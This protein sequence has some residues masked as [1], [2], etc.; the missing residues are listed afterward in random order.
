M[1]A[2]VSARRLNTVLTKL[3]G[4]DQCGSIKGINIGTVIKNTDD[5]INYVTSNQIP[6]LLVSIDFTK[7]FDTILKTLIIDSFKPY[8]FGPDFIHWYT[9]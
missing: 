7:A 3:V 6:G 5:L 2:K 1:L 8:G 4:N 9:H